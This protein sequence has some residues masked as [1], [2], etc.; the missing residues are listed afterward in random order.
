MDPYY[1]PPIKNNDYAFNYMVNPNTNQNYQYQYQHPAHAPNLNYQQPLDGRKKSNQ[2]E[3]NFGLPTNNIQP[4]QQIPFHN[5][6]YVP[7]PPRPIGCYNG[8]KQQNE[9][10][11]G[12]YP[13]TQSYQQQNYPQQQNYQQGYY[14]QQQSYQQGYMGNQQQPDYN[15]LYHIPPP[16]E[17]RD[18][19]H[20][21]QQMPVPYGVMYDRPQ[22]T[23][24]FVGKQRK[25][26]SDMS[27]ALGTDY[28]A[29]GCSYQQPGY[30]KSGFN[31][32]PRPV[33]SQ[34]N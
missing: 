1:I 14:P 19:G 9:Y 28:G 17:I 4:G 18:F 13:Q 23:S 33:P 15:Q 3:Y 25:I 5:D 31:P 22:D 16:I 21:Q 20:L 2:I 6:P 10:Q 7:L 27:A 34:R 24:Q 26:P 11:Q 12:Y 32:S 8:C 29:I 30:Y